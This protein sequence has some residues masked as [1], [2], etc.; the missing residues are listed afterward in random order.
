M[1]LDLK[2][3]LNILLCNC[4]L[5]VYQSKTEFPS[6]KGRRTEKNWQNH[7]KAIKY[8]ANYKYIIGT[9]QVPNTR[10]IKKIRILYMGKCFIMSG[11]MNTFF[12]I[13]NCWKNSSPEYLQFKKCSCFLQAEGNLYQMEVWIYRNEW[14]R[15]CLTKMLNIRSFIYFCNAED[16][17]HGFVY[18]SQVF[19][20][21]A[22]AEPHKNFQNIFYLCNYLKKIVGYLN[23][24]HYDVFQGP[25]HIKWA[26]EMA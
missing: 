2:C 7:A 6:W 20:H 22:T 21:W 24:S 11:K 13:W 12:H 8:D 26:G 23:K 4:F 10:I 19:Y 17:T 18:A 5:V 16:E 3:Y 9:Q 14:S 15:K 1:I 25:K